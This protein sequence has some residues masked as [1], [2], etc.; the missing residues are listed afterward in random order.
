MIQN[1]LFTTLQ[2]AT[3][4]LLFD[5][6]EDN[7]KQLKGKLPN[8]LSSSF[9]NLARGA[10]IAGAALVTAKAIAMKMYEQSERKRPEYEQA[11]WELLTFSPPVRSKVLK[12]RSAGRTVD[13]AGGFG[14]LMDKGPGLENPAY[15]ASANVVSSLTNV[16]LDRVV[17][18]VNNLQ[19][20]MDERNVTWQ[21]IALIAGWGK[22]ELGIKNKKDPKIKPIFIPGVKRTSVK[23]TTAKRTVAKRVS[24]N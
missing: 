9:D 20:A 15:L 24:T 19:A 14:K 22:W 10:G 23:R 7:E 12:L 6:D 4:G 1:L 17:K 18:K 8:I 13:Y 2:Q 3:A 5:E 21:R 11:A 16:P